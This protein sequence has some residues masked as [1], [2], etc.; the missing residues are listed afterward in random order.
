[1]LQPLVTPFSR[2][3]SSFDPKDSLYA[4]QAVDGIVAEAEASQASDVHLLPGP[5]GLELKFR[6]DGVLT[7]AFVF[8]SSTALNIVTRIKVMGGLLTYYTD[9]PQEGRIPSAGGVEMRVSAFPTLHGERI[10]IRLFGGEKNYQQIAEL[11]FSE[12]AAADLR[13]MLTETSGVIV[14]SGPAGSG[15]TTSAYACLREIMNQTDGMRSVSSIEDPV[16]V[17]VDGVAQT[18]VSPGAGFDLSSALR[19]MMRQDPEVILVGEMRD[20]QTA[21]AT[22][23][24]SLTGHLVITTFHAGSAAETISRLLE[25]DIEP[26]VLRSGLL[27]VVNQKLLR[28]LCECSKST[29]D[30]TASRSNANSADALEPRGC[31]RCCGTGYRGR[32]PLVEVLRIKNTE[33]GRAALAAADSAEIERIASQAGM[34][35]FRSQASAAVAA[36]ITSEAEVRRVLGFERR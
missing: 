17:A 3:I 12:S 13:N 16:E 19:Y 5:Q 6:I 21:E 28:R 26:Y 20:R 7:P 15:K 27:G 18:Q 14:I 24:A 36:G 25:M 29:A 4:V 9:R 31:E 2:R 23:Q 33:L 1:M 35:D 34:L 32:F 11:G 22:L 30:A 10:V 8:P